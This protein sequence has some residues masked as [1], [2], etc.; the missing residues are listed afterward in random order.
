MDVHQHNNPRVHRLLLLYTPF[1]NPTAGI[2]D[3]D[4][5]GDG[6]RS[7]GS[8]EAQKATLRAEIAALQQQCRDH[9]TYCEERVS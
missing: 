9:S 6:S 3:D 1:L 2:L 5:D 7:K 4:R 8:Q